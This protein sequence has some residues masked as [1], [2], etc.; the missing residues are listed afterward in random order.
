[1]GMSAASTELVRVGF[2][3]EM[4]HAEPGDPA[5]IAARRDDAQPDED[6]IAAY[7]D[8]GH[9]MVASPGT[10]KDIFD[11]AKRTGP[12]HYMTDGRYLWPGDVAHYVRTY[13]V[14]LPADFLDHMRMN[15]WRVP[16]VEL[17]R[18]RR[19]APPAPPS[20][21]LLLGELA[22]T[23]A[24]ATAADHAQ[25]A[26]AFRAAMAD[27]GVPIT[28]PAALPADLR[29]ALTAAVGAAQAQVADAASA[30]TAWLD[31]PDAATTAEV[32][33]LVDR[34]EAATVDQRAKDRADRQRG[35]EAE[36]RSSI[37]ARLRARGLGPASRPGSKGS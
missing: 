2:F 12:P 25:A 17:A 3:R 33:A 37:T 31:H 35:H 15:G 32:Q 5:L 14:A 22:R 24:S 1:M 26:A 9:V 29:H 34:F 28:D 11:P 23:L 19:P 20:P 4:R 16:P 8:A 18:V 21:S 6:A 30:I 27:A 10:T 7:L 36:A 13:H